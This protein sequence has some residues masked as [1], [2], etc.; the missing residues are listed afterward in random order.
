MDDARHAAEKPA[1]KLELLH[2]EQVNPL[3]ADLDSLGTE[4]M[5][6]LMNRLDQ[7]VPV[8]V[9]EA[10]AAIARA[11]DLVVSRFKAGGRLVYT[12]AGTSGRLGFMDAAE[13]PPTFGVAPDQVTCVM[14][15]GRDAVFKARE[16]AEDDTDQAK[17]DL[18]AFGLKTQDVVLAIASSGRTPYCIGALQYAASIGAGTVSLSCNQN[19]RLSQFAE[20]AIE[21]DSGPEAVMGSTRLKAGTAQKLVLNMISTLAMVRMGH[22]YKNLMVNVRGFNTKLS[23]RMLRIFAEATGNRD[24]ER[25]RSLLAE[26]DGS[27]KLA[28]VMEL[29]GATQAQAREALE[30][31]DGYVRAALQSLEQQGGH[32]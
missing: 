31:H 9:G 27:L 28:I 25:A 16:L 19:A 29:S 22:V 18:I 5:V 24:P 11:I 26:T 14:A 23:N 8:R 2:T 3:T 12:G 32:T 6:R 30:A 15:G 10:A 21:I 17:N 4:D 13:C 20:V 1:E 7:E